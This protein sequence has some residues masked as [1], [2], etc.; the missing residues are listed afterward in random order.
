M[1]SAFIRQVENQINDIPYQCCICD[2]D[3]L[4]LNKCLA[5]EETHTSDKKNIG[6][7]TTENCTYIIKSKNLV[8]NSHY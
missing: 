8:N 1:N 4:Q 3:F 6:C 2:K 7:S 5:F